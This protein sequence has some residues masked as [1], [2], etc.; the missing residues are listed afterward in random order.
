LSSVVFQSK[1]DRPKDTEGGAISKALFSLSLF[2]ARTTEQNIL[3]LQ[4]FFLQWY[5]TNGRKFPW[6]KNNLANYQIVIAETL[7][8]RTKAKTVSVF[9][10]QFHQRLSKLLAQKILKNICDQ[11]GSAL[12][13]HNTKGTVYVVNEAFVRE[14]VKHLIVHSINLDR[15][16]SFR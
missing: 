7:L 11:D 3:D 9:R 1:K 4:K 12:F 2:M 13:R 5:E 15:L 14:K 16:L 6:R 8:Q 10:S